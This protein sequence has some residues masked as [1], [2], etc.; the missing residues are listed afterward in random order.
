MLAAGLVA[1]RLAACVQIEGPIRSHYRWDGRLETAE[2]H[3]MTIKFLPLRQLELEA[4]LHARHPYENPEWLVVRAESVSEKYL[5][6][7]Q[8]NST[9]VP[10]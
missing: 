10:L 8:A 2:E 4:W 6:W 3:R 9:S 1:E 7:A 5:S